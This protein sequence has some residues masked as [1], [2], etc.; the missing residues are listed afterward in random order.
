MQC[1][2]HSRSVND[3]GHGNRKSVHAADVQEK[4]IHRVI[5]SRWWVR[6]RQGLGGIHGVRYTI[7]NVRRRA[8]PSE[9]REKSIS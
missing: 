4:D 2:S 8:P 9:V 7:C 1:L 5:S 6:K 3:R